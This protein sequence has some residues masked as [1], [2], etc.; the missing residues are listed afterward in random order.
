MTKTSQFELKEKLSF[1]EELFP[2]FYSKRM[3]EVDK[4]LTVSVPFDK[5]IAINILELEKTK[6]Q[7]EIAEIVGKKLFGVM[8]EVRRQRNLVD[9]Y[10]AGIL[11]DK[12]VIKK[13][14]V[15]I[16]PLENLY[17]YIDGEGIASFLN[18]MLE[19]GTKSGHYFICINNGEAEHIPENLYDQFK[20][21]VSKKGLKENDFL[22]TLGDTEEVSNLIKELVEE[23]SQNTFIV[24]HNK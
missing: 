16:M 24:K 19:Y 14:V 5:S 22:R 23:E 10:N 4:D 20:T 7:E 21:V 13:Y 8:S 3:N 9:L 6:D 17:K 2:I 18:F 15:Q 11:K 12:P 1:S